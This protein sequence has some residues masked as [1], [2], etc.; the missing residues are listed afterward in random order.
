MT[1]SLGF[2]K[3]FGVIAPSTNTTVQPEFDA[4]RPRGGTNHFG[5]IHIPN[6]PVR[7]DDE[8]NRMMDSIRG[9]MMQAIDR[10][11]TCEPDYL[12]MGMSSETF[13]DG[14]D[15]SIKLRERVEARAGI[16]VAMGSDSCQAALKCYGARRPRVVTPSMP[17]GGAP[18]R[19]FLTDC[20]VE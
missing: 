9:E 6:D 13:W 1:D 20:G 18:V 8:F 14:L 3:K 17:V 2:R 10:V 15:G 16:K 11:M 7:N 12:V 5:R 19:R 4:M